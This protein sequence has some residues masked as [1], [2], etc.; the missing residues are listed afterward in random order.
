MTSSPDAEVN[1]T[2][3]DSLFVGQARR[4]RLAELLISVRDQD[5][6][7]EVR[8]SPV[9]IIDLKEPK[10]GPLAPA[11]VQLWRYADQIWQQ[12]VGGDSTVRLSAAL[13]EQDQARLVVADVPESFDF[14]KVGPSGC[15][16]ESS[17]CRLWGEIRR[18][19]NGRT[20]LVAVAYADWRAANCLGPEAVFQLAKEQGFNRCLIDTYVKDGRSTIDHLGYQCLGEL[21]GIACQQRLWWTLAGSIG[22]SVVPVFEGLGWMPDCF[23][24]RGDVCIGNRGTKISSQLVQTWCDRLNR[25]H[26]N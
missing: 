12:Q 20:E 10:R 3:A 21:H 15:N 23:G 18:S 13:G 14:A 4:G 25:Q 9:G 17:L 2:Q 6:L 19:L 1:L 16:T 5:E 24:V 26:A 8:K 22:A 7:L 11:D